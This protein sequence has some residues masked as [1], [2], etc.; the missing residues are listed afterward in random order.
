MEENKSGRC[1]FFLYCSLQTNT[2]FFLKAFI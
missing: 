1:K 2:L